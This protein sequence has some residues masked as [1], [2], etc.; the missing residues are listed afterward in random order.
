M[1]E[2]KG[3]QFE[4]TSEQLAEIFNAKASYHRQRGAQQ[5]EELPKLKSIIDGL[6]VPAFTTAA[7]TPG[8]TWGNSGY[9]T[10][11]VEELTRRIVDH[12]QEEA[13]LAWYAKHVAPNETFRLGVQDLAPLGI[14]YRIL[15]GI[16]A[17]VR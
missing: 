3:I 6:K 5:A 16:V 10:D 4:V 17:L 14:D 15:S 12:R 9:H 2:G 11:P 1:I 7:G 8:I 13:K